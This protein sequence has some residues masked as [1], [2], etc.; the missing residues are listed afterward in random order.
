MGRTLIAHRS[1]ATC[2]GKAT[3]QM[4]L[5]GGQHTSCVCGMAQ[6]GPET[7][8][9][10]RQWLLE[11]SSKGRLAAYFLQKVRSIAKAKA[12]LRPLAT[13][14]FYFYSRLQVT[15]DTRLYTFLRY[16]VNLH[17]YICTHR[18]YSNFECF[19]I[20]KII[21]YKFFYIFSIQSCWDIAISIYR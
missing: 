1:L 5:G 6:L 18:M 4:P 11:L 9:W 3:S 8:A 13:S 17:I 7:E 16:S 21:P 19:Y 12:P 15:N 20:N 2:L 10:G 14:C